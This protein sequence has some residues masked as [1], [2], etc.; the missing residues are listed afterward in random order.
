MRLGTLHKT[1]APK[2]ARANRDHALDDVKP[3]AQRVSRRIEQSTDTLLLV[4][5]QKRPPETIRTQSR[6]KKY[7]HAHAY[8]PQNNG[9]NDQPPAQACEKNHRN[10]G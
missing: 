2:P 4:I 9:R 5:V 7:H 10:A 1:L 8:Q 6:F 3:F